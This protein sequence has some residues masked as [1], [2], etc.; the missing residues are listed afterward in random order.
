MI[1]LSISPASH[2]LRIPNSCPSSRTCH[3][4]YWPGLSSPVRLHDLFFQC[5]IDQEA[6][7]LEQKFG[8]V[9]NGRAVHISPWNSHGGKEV[10]FGNINY[11]TE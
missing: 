10:L 1:S 5:L 6:V 4:P 8:L 11:K 2:P 9:L 3:L 7:L